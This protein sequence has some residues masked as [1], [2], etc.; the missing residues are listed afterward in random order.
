MVVATHHGV[1][2]LFVHPRYVDDITSAAFVSDLGD[3]LHK[4]ALWVYGHVHESFDYT[5]GR[6]HIVANP[7]GYAL[8]YKNVNC[9]AGLVLENA[10]FRPCVLSTSLA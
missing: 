6:A 9:S 4:A 1:H 3:L 8:N 2:P 5:V 10:A 7:R